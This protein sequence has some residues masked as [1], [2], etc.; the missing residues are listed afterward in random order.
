MKNIAGLSNQQNW[1][2]FLREIETRHSLL[3]HFAFEKEEG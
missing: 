3:Q 1:M 2:E